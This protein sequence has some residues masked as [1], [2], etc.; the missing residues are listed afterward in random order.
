MTALGDCEAALGEYGSTAGALRR[1]AK[2]GAA[3]LSAGMLASYTAARMRAVVS[4]EANS[5]RRR[6]RHAA[7]IFSRLVHATMR[8]R[9]S[10][11]PIAWHSQQSAD[12]EMALPSGVS[13]S[14]PGDCKTVLERVRPLWPV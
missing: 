13:A 11:K 12:C 14:L 1:R 8:G 2:D 7:S 9:E 5:A 4:G 6:E 3:G 10:V